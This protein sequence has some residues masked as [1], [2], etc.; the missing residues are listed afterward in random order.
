[1]NLKG[2]VR[3][4]QQNSTTLYAKIGK[5]GGTCVGEHDGNT[6]GA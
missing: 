5:C 3:T 1:M 2:T 6:E 4:F